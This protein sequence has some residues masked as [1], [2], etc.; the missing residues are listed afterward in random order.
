MISTIKKDSFICC[1]LLGCMLI[2]T[3]G[4]GYTTRSLISNKFRRIYITPFINK[5]DITLD[6]D[7]ANKYKIN[8]PYLET[9]VTKRV[10]DKFLFD[11]NLKP[12]ELASADLVLKGEVIEFRRDPVRYNE[13]DDVEEY[14]VSV[15]VNLSMWDPRKEKLVWKED[16]FRGEATYFVSGP[17]SKSEASAITESIE[18]LARRIVERTVEEW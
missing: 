12:V 9:D 10:I 4:C 14:R 7:V 6:E 3:A 16:G 1:I 17:L 18:D 15:V 5:I 11:G 13:S 8:R 2:V